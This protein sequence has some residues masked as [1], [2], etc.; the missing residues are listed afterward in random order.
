MTINAYKNGVTILNE[1][2]LNMTLASQPF[3]L[4][5]TG[6]Q[7]DAKTGSGV[8][9]NSLAGNNYCARFTLT[10][11]TDIGRIELELDL[12]G[13]G[14][15]VTGEIRSGMVPGSGND[16]T[17][18]KTVVVPKEFIP[19]PAGYWSIPINLSG[20]TSGAQYWI[21]VNTA[22]DAANDVE[23]NGEASQDASYPAYY[24]VG[25][26]GAWTANNA[27][28]FKVFSNNPADGTDEIKHTITGTNL[29]ATFV[30]DVNGLI[31]KAYRY[32]PPEDG[33]TGGIRDVITYTM[34]GNYLM[35]GS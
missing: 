20:L 18:L 32:L 33:S 3:T 27:L 30:Y 1:D 13:T 14:S 7:R 21:K 8:T 31:T 19:N 10:G 25:P 15:D 12:D 2:N 11:A 24:R 5:Y 6:S 35:G 29:M 23:W 28:H 9:E 26:S 16:G 34:S 4:I 22:G 17:L